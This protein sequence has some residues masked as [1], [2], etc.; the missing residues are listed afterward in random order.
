MYV[1][2]I[3]FHPD[4]IQAFK[5]LEGFSGTSCKNL[6]IDPQGHLWAGCTE[7]GV[8]EILPGRDSLAHTFR[9]YG[10]N[11]GL[12]SE[13]IFHLDVNQDNGEIWV[14]TEKGLSRFESRS[15]PSLTSLSAAKV[16]PNP[17]LPKH[18]NV[19]FANL[20]SGS[21]IQ[22]MTQ[23]GSVVWQKTLASGD[24]DQIR[25]NGRNNA[26]ERVKEGVYFYVIRSS[27]ESKNGKIIV[28]R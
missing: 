27:S 16:F 17:F 4:S 19:I 22:V 20:S 9:K 10:L 12:L 1:P 6:E 24:G 26:G 5:T 11:D 7:G 2:S 14:A 21:A 3:R 28:A 13:T 8:F 15:R 18:E 23:S 25:W